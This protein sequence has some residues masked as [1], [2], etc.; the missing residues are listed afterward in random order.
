MKISL[1]VEYACRVLSQLARTY[2][3]STLPHIEELASAEAIPANY[4]VQILNELRTNGIITSRRGKQGGYA[5]ARQPSEISLYDIV[6]AV[7]GALFKASP[8][9]KGDSGAQV[10]RVWREMSEMLEGKARAISLEEFS[11]GSDSSMYHI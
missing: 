8:S 10:V 6:N 5:L 4:L 1:K 11:S 7:D 3:Q 9:L 2:G